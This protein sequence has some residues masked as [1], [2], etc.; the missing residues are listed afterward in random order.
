VLCPA[1]KVES[2]IAELG[3]TTAITTLV[4]ALVL[5]RLDYGNGIVMAYKV[6][7]GLKRVTWVRSFMCLIYRVGVVTWSCHPSNYPLLAA[8]HLRSLLLRQLLI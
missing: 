7:H 2:S 4:V 3:M 6:I 8:E 5:S 1:V